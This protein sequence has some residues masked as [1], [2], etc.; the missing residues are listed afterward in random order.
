MGRST[1]F[2]TNE[3]AV[4]ARGLKRSARS[5]SSEET[6]K[7]IRDTTEGRRFVQEAGLVMIALGLV[8]GCVVVFVEFAQK[9]DGKRE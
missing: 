9:N 8:L 5:G 3:C 4:S 1:N 7:S 2:S 6:S